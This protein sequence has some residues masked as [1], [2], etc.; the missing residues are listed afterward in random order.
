MLPLLAIGG[1]V[2]ALMSA[3]RGVG[4]RV[5]FSRRR[6][7]PPPGGRQRQRRRPRPRCPSSR[8]RSRHRLPGRTCRSVLRRRQACRST[9]MSL[10]MI[11]RRASRQASRPMAGR[12]ASDTSS[13]ATRR[14]RQ[15]RYDCRG[16]ARH[17]RCGVRTV[18]SGRIT[19]TPM[20]H[21]RWIASTTNMLGSDQPEATGC[22]LRG[23]TT[24]HRTRLAITPSIRPESQ[25]GSAS[26]GATSP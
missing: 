15:R 8:R 4:F 24:N 21:T 6:P 16:V 2:G 14:H 23:K 22:P 12:R 17:A 25:G 5:S 26:F 10:P 19:P 11:R 3:S 13:E 1:V 9:N 20:P 18:S 7:P